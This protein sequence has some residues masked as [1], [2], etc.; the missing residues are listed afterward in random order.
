MGHS[1]YINLNTFCFVFHFRDIACIQEKYS[2]HTQF[3]RKVYKSFSYTF[4]KSEHTCNWHTEQER[5]HCQTVEG[6]S[7]SISPDHYQD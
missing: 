2:N 3:P 4:Q 1:E 7:M 6:T 5:E